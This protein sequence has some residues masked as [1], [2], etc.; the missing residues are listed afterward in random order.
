MPYVDPPTR[1]LVDPLID[2]LMETRPVDVPGDL[3]Y[4]VTCV[5]DAW[6]GDKPNY[7]K[8]NAAIGVLECAKLELYR[9]VAVPYE[10][11][12]KSLNGDVYRQRSAPTTLTPVPPPPATASL[13]LQQL[14]SSSGTAEANS[15][16]PLTP[17]AH[18]LALSAKEA[19]GTS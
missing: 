5:V 15:F 6:I 4:L 3:N 2:A 18:S 17:T 16:S 9:R 10:E 8:I 1:K 13:S 7:T 11:A 14:S 12:K 19:S